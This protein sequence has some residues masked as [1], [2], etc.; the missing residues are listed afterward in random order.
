MRQ[1][2]SNVKRKALQSTSVS[3]KRN[4]KMLDIIDQNAPSAKQAVRS[5]I[6]SG[7]PFKKKMKN[8]L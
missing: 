1:K 3:F 8:T 4:H 5:M 2:K 6:S 7:K